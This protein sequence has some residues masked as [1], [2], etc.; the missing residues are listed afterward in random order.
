MILPLGQKLQPDASPQNGLNRDQ[1][2]PRGGHVFRP[3]AHEL[4]R[5]RLAGF[6]SIDVDHRTEFR[7]KIDSTISTRHGRPALLRVDQRVLSNLGHSTRAA[8]GRQHST[9]DS[10][11][12]NRFNHYDGNSDDF[13]VLRHRVRQRADPGDRDRDG[14]PVLQ[15][16]VVGRYDSGASQQESSGGEVVL[17]AKPLGQ[18]G[19]LALHL[20]E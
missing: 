18:F 14:V 10:G 3:A 1:P 19:Q 15:R 8:S 2:S 12:E 17:F 16:K 13:S 11:R 5:R 6:L 7:T 4:G 9:E 20:P